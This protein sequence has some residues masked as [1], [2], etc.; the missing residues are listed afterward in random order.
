MRIRAEA[1]ADHAQVHELNVAAFGGD[2]EA[3]LV[4]LLRARASP[5]V[6]LVADEGGA[7]AGHILFSPVS[8]PGIEGLAMGLA[9]M[10]VA[11]MRQRSGIGS[12]LVM[13]GLA[14]C[15]ELGALAVVVLGHPEF[16]PKFGFSPASRFGLRCEYDVPAEVFMAIELRADALRGASGTV[17]YH[18]A[19]SQL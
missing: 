4:G 11:P 16:Y 1:A 8:L 2:A 19:F 18:A 3:R 5:L 13:A 17:K 10:A 9:P 14:H 7:L 12:A 6:S 15:E